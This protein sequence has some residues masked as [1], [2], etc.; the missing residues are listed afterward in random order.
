MSHK[1]IFL[2][3][4]F[5]LKFI[6]IGKDFY[7]ICLSWQGRKFEWKV[8]EVPGNFIEDFGFAFPSNF[9]LRKISLFQNTK[10]KLAGK[11]IYIANE[12]GSIQKFSPFILNPKIS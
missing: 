5:Q 8:E 6:V 12:G 10:K 1:F 7:F 11:K 4:F 9:L 3:C 2:G